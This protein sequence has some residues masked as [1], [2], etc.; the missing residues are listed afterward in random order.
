MA[1][2]TRSPG[3]FVQMEWAG[4]G[5]QGGL[6][7]EVRSELKSEGG[8]GISEVNNSSGGGLEVLV[9]RGEGQDSRFFHGESE[10]GG[11]AELEKCRV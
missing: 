5:V 11:W 1:D 9:I 6:L 3:H 10:S 4:F 8:I 7:E 2:A